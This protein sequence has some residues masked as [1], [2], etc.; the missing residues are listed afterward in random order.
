MNEIHIDIGQGI[1]VDISACFCNRIF[2]IV[3]NYQSYAQR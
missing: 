2:F 3:Q 1:V